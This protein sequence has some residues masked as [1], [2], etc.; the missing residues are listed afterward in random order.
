[1]KSYEKISKI[2]DVIE[3]AMELKWRWA[4]HVARQPDDRWSKKIEK[5]EPDGK[6]KRGKPSKRWKDDIIEC[7]SIFWR[8]NANN[9]NK[10]KIME[11]TFVQQRTE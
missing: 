4:G 8:R 10:W 5:W 2:K 1:M 9:R 6:R 7:G 3:H 11:K